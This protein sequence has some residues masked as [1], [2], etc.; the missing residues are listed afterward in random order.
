M[1]FKS[2][3]RENEKLWIYA[4]IRNSV[5]G[6]FNNHVKKKRRPGVVHSGSRDKG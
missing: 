1:K 3:Y 5:N 2:W 4:Y 6:S